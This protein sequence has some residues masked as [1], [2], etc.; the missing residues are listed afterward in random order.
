MS[1]D[2][3]DQAGEVPC[4]IGIGGIPDFA[5]APGGVGTLSACGEPARRQEVYRE[6]GVIFTGGGWAGKSSIAAPP[7]APDPPTSE[8]ESPEVHFEKL[9]EFAGRQFDHDSNVRP[10]IREG[11]EKKRRRDPPSIEYRPVVVVRG[12]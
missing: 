9:D 3:A 12:D 11:V 10:Y 7:D 1:F 6:Q 2:V 5:N 4:P 8:G